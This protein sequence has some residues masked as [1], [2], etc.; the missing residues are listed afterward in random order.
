MPAV[1]LAEPATDPGPGRNPEQNGDGPEEVDP[2]VASRRKGV[3][4]DGKRDRPEGATG[5]ALEYPR[6]DE[7]DTRLGEG[8]QNEADGEERQGSEV[9]AIPAKAPDEPRRQRQDDQA[10]G[11]V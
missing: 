9:D 10:R 2:G 8:V 3:E 1:I 5:Q 4:Q 6:Q 11:D 7:L